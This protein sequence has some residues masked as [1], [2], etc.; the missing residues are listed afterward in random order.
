MFRKILN[1]IFVLCVT[2]WCLLLIALAISLAEDPHSGIDRFII[3]V[4]GQSGQF[5]IRSGEIAAWR[6]SLLAV[7]TLGSIV[8]KRYA[9]GTKQ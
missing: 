4:A 8:F 1:G 7:L 6:I 2:A 9:K 3:H 5:G